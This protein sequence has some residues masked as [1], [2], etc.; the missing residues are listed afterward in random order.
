MKALTFYLDTLVHLL[1]LKMFQLMF[2][3][4][5]NKVKTGLIEEMKGS[6]PTSK[7][8]PEF[9]GLYPGICVDYK[10]SSSLHFNRNTSPCVTQKLNVETKNCHCLQ[11][12]YCTCESNGES[13]FELNGRNYSHVMWSNKS[14]TPLATFH[15]ILDPMQPQSGIAYTKTIITVSEKQQVMRRRYNEKVWYYDDLLKLWQQFYDEK[16]SKWLNCVVNNEV[17]KLYFI[18]KVSLL[19]SGKRYYYRNV[20]Y[21]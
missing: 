2:Q 1:L 14:E 15:K 9:L 21:R 5:Q 18:D 16:Q 12:N 4:I 20:V 6:F 19:L 13:N 8:I 7:I 11:A 17:K 3:F 10:R